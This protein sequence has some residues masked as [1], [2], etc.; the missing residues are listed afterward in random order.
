M[1]FASAYPD[2]A[3]SGWMMTVIALVM[4]ASLAAWLILVFRA[5]RQ[6][7]ARKTRQADACPGDRA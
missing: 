7:S 4:V 6:G 3:I 1:S 2:S 5:D